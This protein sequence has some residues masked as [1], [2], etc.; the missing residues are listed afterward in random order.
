MPRQPLD[1]S[2]TAVEISA[3]VQNGG[4]L[5]EQSLPLTFTFSNPV[6]TFSTNAITKD[7][8][9]MVYNVAAAG[10]LPSNTWTATLQFLSRGTGCVRVAANVVLSDNYYPNLASNAYCLTMAP[11]AASPVDVSLTYSESSASFRFIPLYLNF[12][13]EF[14]I[15]ASKIS[16][17]GPSSP[18]VQSVLYYPVLSTSHIVVVDSKDGDVTV[19]FN[20]GFLQDREGVAVPVSSAF[21]TVYSF[22][23]TQ[24]TLIDESFQGSLSSS[25]R[26]VGLLQYVK[27]PKDVEG[28]AASFVTSGLAYDY[29]PSLPTGL[30]Q[31][32]YGFEGSQLSFALWFRVD[33]A[34][35]KTVLRRAGAGE[36]GSNYF[37]RVNEDGEI[38]V[39][40]GPASDKCAYLSSGVYTVPGVWNFVAVT[41]DINGIGDGDKTVFING[42]SSSCRFYDSW[43]PT[44]GALYLAESGDVSLARFVLSRYLLSSAEISAIYQPYAV[45]TFTLETVSESSYKLVSSQPSVAFDVSKLSATGSL[46]SFTTSQEGDSLVLNVVWEEASDP[47]FLSVIIVGEPGLA[48]SSAGKSAYYRA[49]IQKAV[50]EPVATMTSTYADSNSRTTNTLTV[51]FSHDVSVY[52]SVQVSGAS[53]VSQTSSDRRQVI[54]LDTSA[55]GS[56]DVTLSGAKDKLGRAFPEL[57][58]SMTIVSPSE[59][60]INSFTPANGATGIAVGPA[61]VATLVFSNPITLNSDKSVTLSA[62]SGTYTVSTNDCSASGSTLTIPLSQLS[63]IATSGET[64]TVTF[65]SDVVEGYF[66]LLAGMYSFTLGQ[67]VSDVTYTLSPET[68]ASVSA[69]TVFTVQFSRDVAYNGGSIRFSQ[70]NGEKDFFFTPAD[71]CVSLHKRRLTFSV[72]KGLPAGYSFLLSI[73]STFVVASD[74]ANLSGEVSATYTATNDLPFTCVWTPSV[75]GAVVSASSVLYT[76]ECSKHIGAVSSDKITATNAAV[77]VESVSDFG[78]VVRVVPTLS[79]ASSL[80]AV[81]VSAESGYVVEYSASSAAAE[82]F[83]TSLQ[84]V[85]L[86]RSYEM[87]GNGNDSTGR[88]PACLYMPGHFVNGPQNAQVNAYAFGAGVPSWYC[89]AT[90]DDSYSSAAAAFSLSFWYKVD[91]NSVGIPLVSK[92]PVGTSYAVVL[93]NYKLKVLLGSSQ[94]EVDAPAEHLWHH[95]VV[96][97]GAHATLYVDTVATEFSDALSVPAVLE[98]PLYLG[99]P[100]AVSLSSYK[101]YAYAISSAEVAALYTTGAPFTATVSA[102][103]ASIA[104]GTTATFSVEF[105]KAATNFDCSKLSVEPAGSLTWGAVAGSGM[106]YTCPGTIVATSGVLTVSLPQGVVSDASGLTNVESNS[107]LVGVKAPVAVAGPF[108]YT[109]AALPISDPSFVFHIDFTFSTAEISTASFSATSGTLSDASISDRVY[110]ATFTLNPN[111][112]VNTPARITFSEPVCGDSLSEPCVFEFPFSPAFFTT[113]VNKQVGDAYNDI[114]YQQYRFSTSEADYTINFEAQCT[115]DAIVAVR[116]YPINSADYY[117]TFVFGGGGNSVTNVRLTKDGNNNIATSPA[118]NSPCEG[119]STWVSLWIKKSGSTVS[120]GK[121]DTTYTQLTNDNHNFSGDQIFVPSNWNNI[122]R[123]RNVRITSS[124]MTSPVPFVPFLFVDRSSAP[125]SSDVYFSSEPAADLTQNDLELTQVTVSDFTK[126]SSTHYTFS[127]SFNTF[128]SSTTSFLEYKVGVPAGVL[129]Q[130]GSVTTNSASMVHAYAYAQTP[131]HASI[132]WNEATGSKTIPIPVT[133]SFDVNAN[134]D[135][136]SILLPRG[137]SIVELYNTPNSVIVGV[138]PGPSGQATVSIPEGAV[139][140]GEHRS[141]AASLD[142]YVENPVNMALTQPSSGYVYWP[143]FWRGFEHGAVGAIFSGSSTG[144]IRMGF[145]SIPQET[146]GLVEVN[147]GIESGYV[148]NVRVLGE[149]GY[150][151]VYTVHHNEAFV[152]GYQKNYWVACMGTVLSVGSG[153]S[154]SADSKVFEYDFG[155]SL[156]CLYFTFASLSSGMSVRSIHRVPYDDGESSFKP[157]TITKSFSSTVANTIPL[158]LN[159]EFEGRT[160]GLDSWVVSNGYISYGSKANEFYLYPDGVDAVAYAYLPA[161]IVNEPDLTSMASDIVQVR[162]AD[163]VDTFYVPPRYGGVQCPVWNSVFV[164]NSSTQKIELNFSLDIV[165]GETGYLQ[166]VFAESAASYTTERYELNVC[167]ETSITH[168]TA[169]GS[170][171]LVSGPSQECAVGTTYRFKLVAS[172]AGI[173][174]SQTSGTPIV[175]TTEPLNFVVG[176]YSFS[177]NPNVANNYAQSVVKVSHL[178]V[179]PP[180]IAA[181]FEDDFTSQKSEW[182]FD[183]AVGGRDGY[184]YEYI[185]VDGDGV[186]SLHSTANNQPAWG[187]NT[188]VAAPYYSVNL[189]ASWTDVIVKAKYGQEQT[190]IQLCVGLAR[191]S[192]LTLTADGFCV[193]MWDIGTTNKQIGWQR[194]ASTNGGGAWSTFNGDVNQWF[195]MKVTNTGNS[196]VLSYRQTETGINDW[197]TVHTLTTSNAPYVS[198]VSRIVLY[199]QTNESANKVAY[200]TDF[201]IVSSAVN[202]DSLIGCYEPF[203]YAQ[204]VTPIQSDSM[205]LFECQASCQE[206]YKFYALYQGNKCICIPEYNVVDKVR[207][208]NTLCSTVCA[209]DENN[210]CGGENHIAFYPIGS[211]FI[212]STELNNL[213]GWKGDI[214]NSSLGRYTFTQSGV[215]V[216]T[217]GSTDISSSSRNNAPAVWL[218]VPSTFMATVLVDMRNSPGQQVAG[219][220][221][222]DNLGENFLGLCALDWWTTANTLLMSKMYGKSNSYRTIPVDTSKRYWLRLTRESNGVNYCQYKEEGSNAWSIAYDDTT[223]V[224]ASGLRIGLFGKSSSSPRSATYSSFTLTNDLNAPTATLI[225]SIGSDTSYAQHTIQIKFSEPVTLTGSFDLVNCEVVSTSSI[226]TSLYSVVIRVLAEGQFSFA[227]NASSAEDHAGNTI[228]PSD[229]VVSVY[230]SGG[231]SVN[232]AT[233]KTYLNTPRFTVTIT[234]ST[235]V[236]NFEM[237]SISITNGQVISMNAVSNTQYSI[238]CEASSNGIVS[239]MVP[240]GA[241]TTSEGQTNIQSNILQVTYDQNQLTV[242]LSSDQPFRNEYVDSLRLSCLS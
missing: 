44:S 79:D 86:T 60:V 215:I 183:D 198:E 177:S 52:Y 73:P 165:S 6:S 154:I 149:N 16:V 95:V 184:S 25:A 36:A 109:E 186:L 63:A 108:A 118:N 62:A 81:S 96:A 196:Y 157:V 141:N 193:Q 68:G 71:A 15:D 24:T 138:I 112:D 203:T 148:S 113:T 50:G 57:A 220:A 190:G 77:S 140:N 2:K 111:E 235:I 219:I 85:G 27:D 65:G 29:S 230:H 151:T 218:S 91:D 123:Y 137:G 155:R 17:A 119:M 120:M 51:L 158:I 67:A 191:V 134:V 136:T 78:F 34:G 3:S 47:A 209:G 5:R 43:A 217:L 162:L 102:P 223:I 207:V 126:V 192:D 144:G 104:Y 242:M 14:R 45:P 116:P 195:E 208:S 89:P 150:S 12:D 206:N 236:S 125:Y 131:I 194:A 213:S 197:V 171:T 75:S 176:A 132:T 142:I 189:P 159:V 174:L 130:A 42:V 9:V 87:M 80:V 122:V 163:Y 146:I 212:Y 22:V 97:F 238:V 11:T 72:P 70:I 33:A 83:S 103:A 164:P 229:P 224:S 35:Q 135:I 200:F 31:D 173:S 178:G 221:L 99:S 105:N 237:S 21:Q 228:V 39:A 92:G 28:S 94:L 8:N 38:V 239:I 74:A 127:T 166:F 84:V 170:Q 46:Y 30:A 241:A 32:Y 231:V 169:E 214:P 168:V 124:A 106:S 147:L 121:G 182:Y 13:S 37:V 187:S 210:F 152:T 54:V 232:L 69:D 199:I 225:H 114:Y 181:I 61:T 48:T 211:K 179:N 180:D 167:G 55:P 161:R 115:G 172:T 88:G 23:K 66:G 185:N 216:D 156:N 133:I 202:D 227:L 90:R 205:T 188:H 19:T 76:V 10:A 139:T 160:I 100:N 40:N 1:P 234:F 145:S 110:T 18:V 143:T 64:V 222:Y 240:S 4:I 175:A 153:S 107:V 41:I 7:A 59:L 128:D 117:N 226:T 233:E 201:R 26:Q 101:A 56:V 20:S 129:T 58:K 53:I 98:A 93:E 204:S 49:V 82:A